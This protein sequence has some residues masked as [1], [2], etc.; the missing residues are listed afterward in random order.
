MTPDNHI[1]GLDT[2]PQHILLDR[3]G[4]GKGQQLLVL[5][6]YLVQGSAASVWCKQ[7]N[8]KPAYVFQT[9]NPQLSLLA[10]LHTVLC[11]PLA[12]NRFEAA[13]GWALQQL[14]FTQP[15]CRHL[16]AVLAIPID[17]K[18]AEVSERLATPF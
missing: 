9:G 11:V 13:W 16:S 15:R 1:A 7:T 18:A 4:N 17:M 5:R 3:W 2:T 14:G 8:F 12:T 6:E 10:S